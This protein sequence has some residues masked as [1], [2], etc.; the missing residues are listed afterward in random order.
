MKPRRA[1]RPDA[2]PFDEIRLKVVPRYKTSGLS[3]DEWRISVVM[4]LFRKG[5]LKHEESIAH[6]MENAMAFL[7]WKATI[8]GENGAQFF[9]GEEN[10][11]DQEGCA[12]Q[13]T[14]TYRMG[15]EFCRHG[16]ETK[17]D[18]IVIRKFCERHK[19]RGDCGLEDADR[20]YEVAFV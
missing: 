9:G 12:E 5:I 13:A 18:G 20:N 11:C 15:S 1:L 7:S 19:T 2:Q 4:Q 3:G 16:H 17:C 6:D 8:A 14:V 10:W